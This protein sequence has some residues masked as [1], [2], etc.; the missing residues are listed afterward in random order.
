MADLD[1]Y[2]VPLAALLASLTVNGAA[3]AAV[4]TFEIDQGQTYTPNTWR[5]EGGAREVERHVGRYRESITARCVY[6]AGDTARQQ[7]AHL[8]HAAAMLQ[9]AVVALNSP[10]NMVLADGLLISDVNPVTTAGIVD[11][12]SVKLAASVL[13]ITATRWVRYGS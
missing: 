11:A 8:R 13:E 7:Q 9:A 10:S 5:I 4:H 12:G 1:D 6:L 2:L 3:A